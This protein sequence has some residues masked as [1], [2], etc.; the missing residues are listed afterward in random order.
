M[1]GIMVDIQCAA[2]EIRRGKKEERR[3]RKRPQDES[4]MSVSATQGGHNHAS[5]RLPPRRELSGAILELKFRKL[6][7]SFAETWGCGLPSP[8]DLLEKGTKYDGHQFDG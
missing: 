1:C 2:A 6:A 8:K 7:V 5:T 3:R 4:I